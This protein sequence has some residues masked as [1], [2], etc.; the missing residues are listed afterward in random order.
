MRQELA[1]L[2]GKINSQTEL[3]SV[4]FNSLLV[5][6][7]VRNQFDEKEYQ[8]YEGK[9]STASSREEIEVVVKEFLLKVKQKNTF[10]KP[11]KEK[12]ERERERQK[13]SR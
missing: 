10:L 8:D 7:Q 12:R 4:R 3:K 9:I 2:Q 5:L 6:R 1:A 13:D 11:S